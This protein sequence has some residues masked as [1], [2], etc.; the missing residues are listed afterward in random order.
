MMYADNLFTLNNISTVSAQATIDACSRRALGHAGISRRFAGDEANEVNGG[1][2]IFI[3]A[4]QYG[5]SII[6]TSLTGLNG[7]H[8]LMSAVCVLLADTAGVVDVKLR[9]RTRGWALTRAIRI[10]RAH[11]M[12]ATFAGIA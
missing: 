4:M 8:E 10:N 6:S 2:V 11:S 12:L 3:D 9:N 7:M 1:D 5:K